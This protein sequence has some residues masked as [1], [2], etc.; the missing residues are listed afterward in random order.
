MGGLR[1]G[2]WWILLNRNTRLDMLSKKKQKKYLSKKEKDW[3]IQLQVFGESGDPEALH[4]LRLG[5]K[6]VQAFGQMVKA[7]S[8]K[9]ASK[10]FDLL[11][12]MFLHG[13][14][15]RDANTKLPL[16]EHFHS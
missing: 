15:I 16:L 13:G 3:L 14:K 9:L 7:C 11:K 10:D 8:G 5:V 4:R 2:M 1:G 6:K 12:K